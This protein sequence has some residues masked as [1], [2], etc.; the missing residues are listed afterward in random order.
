MTYEC[1]DDETYEFTLI[2][3]RDCAANG[4]PF[5]GGPGSPFSAQVTVYLGTDTE[6]FAEPE[7][8][9]PVISQLTFE[10]DSNC[11]DVSEQF[12][13][14]QAT[15]QWQLT[16]PISDQPYHVVYQRCC[17]ST[18]LVNLISAGETGNTFFIS[19]PPAAQAICNQGPVFTEEA[20]VLVYANEPLELDLSAVEVEGDSLH[21]V[22]CAPVG[23]GGPDTQAP[24]LSTGVAPQPDLPPPYEELSF[25]NPPYSVVQPLDADPILQLNSLTGMLTGTPQSIGRYALTLCVEE[26]RNGELL[27]VIRRNIHLIVAECQPI[28][29]T[30]SAHPEIFFALSPNPT[31]EH[32]FVQFPATVAS[33]AWLDVRDLYGKLIETHQIQN[34]RSLMLSTKNL[35]PGI[36]LITLITGSS[37]TT[38]RLVVL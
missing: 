7:L 20:P 36:Y 1:L 18:A 14:Q 23:G 35:A 11:V 13:A 22:L 6:P 30:E 21:Y 12:C 37:R 5:D 26:Y 19:I 24:F 27:S 8:P 31:K 34:V 17:R 10:P 32:V 29:S 25:V 2:L 38:R 9:D 28:V 4:A 16:L 15:Y 3:L 33:E